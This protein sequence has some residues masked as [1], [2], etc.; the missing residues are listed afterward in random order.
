MSVLRS[1]LALVPVAIALVIFGAVFLL[2]N[3]SDR[4]D[5]AS[6]LPAGVE[7]LGDESPNR[8]DGTASPKMGDTEEA[9]PPQESP[10]EEPEDAGPERVSFRP[11]W[12]FDKVYVFEQ[13]SRTA[14]EVD[15]PNFGPIRSKT[16]MAFRMEITCEER[17]GGGLVSKASYEWI[18][19]DSEVAGQI[20]SLDSRNE[21]DREHAAFAPLAALLDAELTVIVNEAGEVLR[22]KGLPKIRPVPGAQAAMALLNED[23]MKEFYSS[24]FDLQAPEEGVAIG[25]SWE[26]STEVPMPPSATLS[27][28]MENRFNGFKTVGGDSLAEVKVTGF[29]ELGG[30]EGAA[31]ETSVDRSRITGT[32]LFDP[33]LGQTRSLETRQELALET[34]T[35]GM[36]TQVVTN[37]TTILKLIEVRD[38]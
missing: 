21:A 6:P 26:T 24:S 23:T 8:A 32:L 27:V 16:D 13:E 29:V 20:T 22:V 4:D 12:D 31:S 34:S 17:P 36:T 3:S 7:G 37:N 33:E 1:P 25:E 9:A 2:I 11:E 18:T 5:P 38:R 30:E 19:L 14:M 35:Q 15:V 10:E 28:Q